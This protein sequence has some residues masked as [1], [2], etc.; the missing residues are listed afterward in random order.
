LTDY[1]DHVPSA[2]LSTDELSR[3]I[4]SFTSVERV[5]EDIVDVL[6]IPN[7]FLRIIQVFALLS[8]CSFLTDYF[9]H[10]PSAILSTDEQCLHH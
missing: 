7:V 3:W 1:F 2:I 6:P 5:A 4:T 8:S 9:D 10:V